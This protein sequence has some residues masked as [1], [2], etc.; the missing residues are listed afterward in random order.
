MELHITGDWVVVE[1][2]SYDKE[3]MKAQFCIGCNSV[4]ATE[5]IA[6]VVCEHDYKIVESVSAT[7]TKKGNT[8]YKCNV[9]NA[10][11]S[12]EQGAKGHHFGETR[13]VEATCTQKGAV[14]KICKNCNHEEQ[15]A[16]L[17]FKEHDYIVNPNKEAVEATCIKT[18][19]TEGQH[20]TRC[21]DKTVAQE[22]VPALNHKGTLVQ[23]EAKAKTCT[24]VGWEAYEYCTA[25]DYATTYVE[26][27]ATGE[28]IDADGDT[29]CDNGGEQL[30][31]EDC[32]RPVHDDSF[33][34]S[35][36]CLILMLINLIK[37]MF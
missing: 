20:C 18:G 21:D 36:I 32:G 29:M 9:C 28:H 37:T 5:P 24:T 25:C 4:L 22:V 1:A 19:L 8:T 12:V 30:T 14:Y 2:P 26:F 35:L 7:C 33:A 16:T 17:D 15:T 34:Q 23:V 3:G 6:K 11:Y 31:C 10:S 13:T 27:P